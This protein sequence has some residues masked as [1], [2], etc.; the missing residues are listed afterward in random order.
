MKRDALVCQHLEGISRRALEKYQD[1]VRAY[2]GRRGGIYAIYKRGVVYYVGLA[3]NL[4]SRL[5]H[6]LRDRHGD[7]WDRFSV[8]LTI[9]DRHMKE[10]E[11]MLL[12]ISKP[13]GNRQKGQFANSEN[14]RRRFA[15]DLKAHHRE[16]QR[17]ILGKALTPVEA[18]GQHAVRPANSISKLSR[19]L[20]GVAH[21]LRAYY[22]GRTY[23]ARARR[24][25]SIRL[26]GRLYDSPSAAAA[27]ICKRPIS[28]WHFWR[29]ERAPGDWVKLVTLV[30]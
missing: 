4:R 28:G 26:N 5:K 21:R 18:N 8:Y 9:G 14:L 19:V 6:H 15:Q 17:A 11:S 27:S 24:D 29:F 25:G 13:E 10:L 23:K 20:N 7:A 22:K 2:V 12:R 1:V 16:E 3:S 30:R